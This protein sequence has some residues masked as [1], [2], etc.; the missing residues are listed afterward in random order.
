[1]LRLHRLAALASLSAALLGAGRASAFCRTSVCAVDGGHVHGKSCTP[2]E[3]DE[4]AESW[5]QFE[6]MKPVPGMPAKP[7][8]RGWMAGRRK[9]SS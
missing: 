4:P 8:R 1:M 6:A 3:P 9:V 7:Q 5:P 2:A